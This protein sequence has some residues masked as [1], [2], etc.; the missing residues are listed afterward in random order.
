MHVVEI[1]RF[2]WLAVFESFWYQKLALN[3]AAFYLV[4]VCGTNFLS[5]CHSTS[6]LYK[7]PVGVSG[8][9]H[10]CYVKLATSS[11]TYWPHPHSY[12]FGLVSS[13]RKHIPG[14][15]C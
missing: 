12:G 13:V 2:D 4:Q 7:L 9:L 14:F 5:M 8:V 11:L 1:V 10:I 15:F 3:R 6:L